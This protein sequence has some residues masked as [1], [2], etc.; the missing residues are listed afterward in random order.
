[1]LRK[2]ILAMAI[3]LAM[4][5]GESLAAA[6]QASALMEECENKTDLCLGFMIAAEPNID[7][8]CDER[9]FIAQN[10]GIKGSIHQQKASAD[11]SGLPDDYM[12]RAEILRESFLARMKERPFYEYGSA[13]GAVHYAMGETFPCP[14]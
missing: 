11:L 5:N 6:L 12:I 14:Y 9:K 10:L 2:T 8:W 1:M 3:T 13:L 4:Q 7:A